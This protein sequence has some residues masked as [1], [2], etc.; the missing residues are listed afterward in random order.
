MPVNDEANPDNTA[1]AS[2]ITRVR[3]LGH[4]VERDEVIARKNVYRV[5]E[6]IN[7]LIRTSRFHD[8]RNTYFFGLTRHILENFAQLPCPVI[9]FVFSDTQET[10]LVP[11]RL[12][13]EQREKLNS[14]A[15]QYKL[16]VDKSCQVGVLK[17]AGELIDLAAFRERYDLLGASSTLASIE[18]SPKDETI[19]HSDIQ[20]MLLEIGDSRG[21]QT[22]CA[23]RKP[24]FNGKAIGDIATTSELPQFPGINYEIVCRIDVVWLDRSF[25]VNALVVELTTV[26]WSGLVRLGELRRLNT[27]FHV[28]T[29]DDLG[30]F[31]RRVA[32][33]IFAEI[34]NRCHHA[35]ATEI[36]ELYEVESRVSELRRKLNL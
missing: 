19:G 13:W 27:V 18:R 12:I 23:D 7:L 34:V 25:P 15:K 21:L 2:F 17:G 4:K 8:A 10:L 3:E 30:A 29:N 6:K 26:I 14:N 35:N 11:A 32:G 22:Y 16:Q 33:D 24:V 31:K 5:D 36:R 28:V 9:A 20:G 1:I